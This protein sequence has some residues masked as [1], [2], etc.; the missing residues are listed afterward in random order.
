LRGVGFWLVRDRESGEVVGRGGLSHTLAT[1]VDEVEVGW[2]IAPSRWRQG[3]ATELASAAIEFAWTELGL[4]RLIAYTMPDNIPS[5]RV[6]EKTGFRYER[7]LL[8]EGVP[9]V[10]YRR[11]RC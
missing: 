5:R 7:G 1:G 11:N 6:M 10:L 4:D 8:H 9:H 2:T 3:L